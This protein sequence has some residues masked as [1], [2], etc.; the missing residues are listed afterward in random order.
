MHCRFTAQKDDVGLDGPAGKQFKPGFGSCQR[1]G[2]IAV[3]VA[4]DVAVTSGQVA[5]GGD[6]K[7]DIG[8]IS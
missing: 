5:A 1:Q 3:L 8:G 7:K 4:I 6:V 2:F